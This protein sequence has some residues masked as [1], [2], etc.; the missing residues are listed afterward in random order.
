MYC[1]PLLFLGF[2]GRSQ[3]WVFIVCESDF[4]SHLSTAQVKVIKETLLFGKSKCDT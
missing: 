1:V 3:D 4:S 2:K